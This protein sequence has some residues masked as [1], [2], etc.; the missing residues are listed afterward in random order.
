VSAP[1]FVPT[2]PIPV[3]P[4]AYESPPRRFDGWTA[5]RPGDGGERQGA[6]LGSQGPDQGYAYTLVATVEDKVTLRPDE[7]WADASTLIVSV[8]LKRAS[9]YGRAP[10]IHDIGLAMALFGYDDASTDDALVDYRSAAA[11]E[12]SHS[13]H[14]GRLRDVVD[15]I[16]DNTLKMKPADIAGERARNWQSLVGAK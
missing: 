3:T 5:T 7:H 1:K 2:K 13:H 11:D 12:V 4:N 8:A 6:Q 10:V 9:I 16:S 15:R 14:Y